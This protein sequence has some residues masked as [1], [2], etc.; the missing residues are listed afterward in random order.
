[1]LVYKVVYVNKDGSMV[2]CCRNEEFPEELRLEYKIGESTR[3]KLIGS[4]I[5]VFGNLH[6]A[7]HWVDFTWYYNCNIKILECQTKA[8]YE[9]ITPSTYPSRNSILCFWRDLHYITRLGTYCNAP[10]G[11][12]HCDEVTPIRIVED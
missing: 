1:M 6:D 12:L 8:L 9:P 2:S 7:K 10:E 11:T 5:F 3:P 4:R